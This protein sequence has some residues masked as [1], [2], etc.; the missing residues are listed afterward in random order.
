ML[1]RLPRLL[2]RQINVYKHFSGAGKVCILLRRWRSI[3]IYIYLIPLR[4]LE[5][6]Y[7]QLSGAGEVFI[8]T[9]LAPEKPEK[10]LYTPQSDALLLELSNAH[11]A[12][13]ST[14]NIVSQNA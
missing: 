1:L 6:I 13:K 7:T 14:F 5:S 8:Y 3:S 12:A 11:D 2:Q 10:Y 4:R 9:Y